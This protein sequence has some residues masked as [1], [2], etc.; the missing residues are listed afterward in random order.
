MLRA[1]LCAVTRASI[2]PS[3]ARHI[4]GALVHKVLAENVLIES[5]ERASA[6]EDRFI[7]RMRIDPHHP[8][9][10]EHALDHVPSMMLIEGGRQL[11]IAVSHLFLG[12]PF[13][14]AFAP[15]EIHARFSQYA[16]LDGPVEIHCEAHDKKYRK[17]LLSRMRLDGSF[18]Q[19]GRAIGDMSGQWVMLPAHVYARL[20][21]DAMTR[22]ES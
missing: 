10:F 7:A 19:R 15:T 20:R 4:D 9:F 12:V 13:G 6:D 2:D 8:F 11:G 1:W 17:G 3:E 21:A 16:E 5:I 14:T 18:Q 22:S